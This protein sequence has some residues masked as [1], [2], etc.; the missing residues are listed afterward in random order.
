MRAVESGRPD[1]LFE[2]PYAQ[3]F[4]DAG[5]TEFAEGLFSDGEQRERGRGRSELG[6]LFYTHAVVRTRFY[7]DFLLSAANAGCEQVVLLAAGLDTRAFRL[8][9]PEHTRLFELDLPDVLA[10]KQ[11]V[12]TERGAQPV[13]ARTVV[14]VDLRTEWAGQLRSEGFHS[15][16]PTVWLAEGLLVY[17]SAEEARALLES[18]GKLSAAGSQLS[19]EQASPSDDGLLARARALPGAQPWAAL[20]KGGLGERAPDWLADHG[21]RHEVH[22]R[23]RLAASYGRSIDEPSAGGFLTAVYEGEAPHRTAPV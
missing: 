11:R 13:C 6:A 7:D 5:R 19:F 2:D 14:A 15:S 12:L 1:R 23:A 16:V 9:W 3:A 18:V 21:W 22:A 17:L 4:V 20:L 8:P 10:F